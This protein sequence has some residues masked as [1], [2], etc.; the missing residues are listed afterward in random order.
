MLF[1]KYSKNNQ[2]KPKFN[3]HDFNNIL[4]SVFSLKD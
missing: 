3:D 4:T 2:S 1:E